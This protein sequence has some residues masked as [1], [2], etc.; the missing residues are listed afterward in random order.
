MQQLPEEVVMKLVLARVALQQPK[1]RAEYRIGA[2]RGLVPAR[3]PRR[4]TANCE[5]RLAR[6]ESTGID[7]SRRKGAFSSGLEMSRLVCG[8]FNTLNHK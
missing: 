1:S 2:T 3:R 7:R 4:E 8:V 6:G 5:S